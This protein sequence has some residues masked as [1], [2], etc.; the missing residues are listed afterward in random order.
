MKTRESGM[1]D[2]GLWDSFFAP[3]DVLD[4]VQF[5]GGEVV[6]FGCGYGTFTLPA[7]RRTPGVVHALDIDPGMVRLVESKAVAAGLPNVHARLRDFVAEGTGLPDASADYAMLFN[8]LHCEDPDV[9][10]REARRVLRPAGLLGIVHWRYDP[11]TPRGPNMAIRPR[12]EDC[13]DWAS[14]AGFEPASNIIDLPPYHYGLVIAK[15][16]SP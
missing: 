1:P 12:A 15:P 8:I 13:R 3:D 6:E 11:A 14:S 5:R 10:L 7:A 2:E 4:R 9:L 16:A